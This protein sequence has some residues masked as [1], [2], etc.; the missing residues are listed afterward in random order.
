MKKRISFDNHDATHIYEF[1]QA[2]KQG[3]KTNNICGCGR[4]D[5]IEKRLEKFIGKKS[6]K[7]YRDIVK[8]NPYFNK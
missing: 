1:F 5:R 2:L 7:W 4:D 6:A 3:L 8:K